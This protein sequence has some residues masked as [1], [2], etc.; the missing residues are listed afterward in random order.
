M[1]FEYKNKYSLA[2]VSPI[3]P[4][5]SFMLFWHQS[6]TIEV[7][8]DYVLFVAIWVFVKSCMLAVVPR[9]A[10]N[11][12]TKCCNYIFTAKR[13][14]PSYAVR[15]NQTN[16]SIS[17]ENKNKTAML[18]ARVCN[19]EMCF[20]YVLRCKIRARMCPSLGACR[21]RRHFNFDWILGMMQ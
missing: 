9:A 6:E 13:P 15:Y 11:F 10:F 1:R 3:I 17:S 18:H 14:G 8:L 2:F 20:D 7:T 5:H 19:C 12:A 16:D 4:I 21:S